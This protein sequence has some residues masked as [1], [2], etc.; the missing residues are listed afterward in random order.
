[1]DLILGCNGFIRISAA[2]PGN[3]DNLEFPGSANSAVV[4]ENPLQFEAR[5]SI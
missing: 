2:S 5:E 1:M 4:G 3:K